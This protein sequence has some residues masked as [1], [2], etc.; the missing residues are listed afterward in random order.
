M[1]KFKNT[2]LNALAAYKKNIHS[3]VRISIHTT[4]ENSLLSL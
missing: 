4:D 1:I 2:F 3:K